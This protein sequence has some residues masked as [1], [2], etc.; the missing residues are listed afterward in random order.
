LLSR[1]IEMM[2]TGAVLLT[3]GTQQFTQILC[4][5]YNSSTP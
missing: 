4:F 5:I 3:T 2:K 1:E